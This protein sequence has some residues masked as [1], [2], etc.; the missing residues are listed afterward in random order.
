M[1]NSAIKKNKPFD[2]CAACTFYLGAIIVTLVCQALAG[3]VAA[4][5]SG[6]YPD[7][8]ND[9]DFN[10]A[11]MIIIQLASLAFIFTFFKMNRCKPQF[12]IFKSKS[13]GKGITAVG[14]ILPIVAAAALLAGMYL[15]T[16]WYG[17]FTQYALGIPPEFG[18]IPLDS[19]SSKVMIVIASVFLAPICEET[20]YRGVLF[21]GLKSRGNT[22]RAVMLSALAFTLMHM[23]PIQV[24][25]QFAVGVLSAYLMNATDRLYPSV[26]LHASANS[27]ALV[28]QLTPFAGVLVGCEAWLV[29][30]IAAAAFITL[31]LF[32]ASG[33]V[34]FAIVKFGFKLEKEKS[35]TTEASP[36][37]VE[38]EVVSVEA[39]ESEKAAEALAVTRNKDGAVRYWIAIGIS[40]LMFIFNLIAAVTL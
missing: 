25:F 14:I 24:V 26:L 16:L 30:N 23:S 13:S 40:A 8:A 9:D 15:P 3:L 34:L 4:A 32:V 1:L 33:A 12:G 11:F 31:G 35:L 22:L 29:N 2:F 36:A 20:I 18:N 7:I 21:N 6:G 39:D 38:P 27:L 28:M 37:K 19:A 17:Y 5:F 10:T